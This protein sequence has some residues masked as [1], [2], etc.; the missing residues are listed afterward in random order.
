MEMDVE[1]VVWKCRVEQLR[2]RTAW[3]LDVL[4]WICV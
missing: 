4:A 2:N 3:K 1:V